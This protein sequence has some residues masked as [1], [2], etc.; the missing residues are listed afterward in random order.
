MIGSAAPI[1]LPATPKVRILLAGTPEMGLIE[2][3][4]CGLD[5]EINFEII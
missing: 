2:A 1:D 3:H 5:G 4:K